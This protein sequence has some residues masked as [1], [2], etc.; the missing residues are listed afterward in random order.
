MRFEKTEVP[1][2][3]RSI[4]IQGLNDI[5][6]ANMKGNTAVRDNQRMWIILISANLPRQNQSVVGKARPVFPDSYLVA[7]HESS[8]TVL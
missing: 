4:F 8:H 7:L 1:S 2:L 5:D 3:G 6:R